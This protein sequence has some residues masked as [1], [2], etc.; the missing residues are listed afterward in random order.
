MCIYIYIHCVALFCASVLT[1][2]LIVVS[3]HFVGAI[4]SPVPS[5]VGFDSAQSA[6]ISRGF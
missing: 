3:F 4:Y 1:H 5:F 6:L 2:A